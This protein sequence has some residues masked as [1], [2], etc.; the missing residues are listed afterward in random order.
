[1]DRIT[2]LE[3]FVH[4]VDLGTLSKAAE[5]L[6]ISNASAT[7]H[8]N[9]LESRLKVRLLE[10]N[11]RRL[12]LTKIGHDFYQR[13]KNLLNE[14][15][16]AEAAVN[17]S[18]VEPTGT[19]TVTASISFSKLHI[20]P[21]LPEFKKRY[22]RIKI[23]IVGANRY[24]DI[25]DSGID[26]AIRTREFE[27]DSNITVR[28]L[29]ENRRVL[30]ASP[31]YLRRRGAP[32]KVDK[33]SHHDMIVYSHAYNPYRLNFSRGSDKA[34][35]NIEPIL[36]SNDGQIIRSAALAGLGI[37]VQPMYVIYDDLVAGR[38]IPVLQDWHL[39]KLII[40][41]A[42]QERRYMPAKTRL[43]IDFLLEDFRKKGFEGN[44]NTL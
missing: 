37:L 12:S 7:R 5:L 19:L 14:Y 38:L 23:H 35:V 6:D 31:E 20:A 26:L 24:Y 28:R 13:S 3:L 11:T 18:V 27:P 30:A 15:H 21:L 43:F 9:S 2:E 36:E 32:K 39:P 4:A 44:W 1:M 40:N 16:E 33:L 42:F 10:R 34:S 17:S 8:L 22:P 29:A 25:M 41:I